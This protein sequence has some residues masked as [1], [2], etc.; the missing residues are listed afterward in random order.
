MKKNEKTWEPACHEILV[1]IPVIHSVIQ[2]QKSYSWTNESR[3]YRILFYQLSL[4]R[5]FMQI[6]DHENE[7]NTFIPMRQLEDT[8][9]PHKSIFM[10][11]SKIKNSMSGQLTS[12]LFYLQ[13]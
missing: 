10:H 11:H 8:T 5:C 9:L 6:R 1:L 3:V 13:L 2:R 7:K 4:N 12:D